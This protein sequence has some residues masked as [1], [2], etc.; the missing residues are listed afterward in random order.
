[1]DQKQGRKEGRPHRQSTES[2]GSPGIYHRDSETWQLPPKEENCFLHLWQVALPQ[3]CL[4]M[5][6]NTVSGSSCYCRFLALCYFE[7]P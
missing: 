5:F 1:M 3:G 6:K 7:I 2:R 4:Q